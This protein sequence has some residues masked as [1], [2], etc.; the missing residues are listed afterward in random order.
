MASLLQ[1]KDT[2]AS[3]LQVKDT[4]ANLLLATDNMDSKEVDMVAQRNSRQ[5]DMADHPQT[6]LP[7]V[8]HRAD[9]GLPRLHRGTSLSVCADIRQ[10]TGL[11]RD[12]ANGNAETNART[13]VLTS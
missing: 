13:S 3:L 9:M 7:I 5:V 11:V 1:V 8:G 4:M 10:V 6:N 2:M 12:T